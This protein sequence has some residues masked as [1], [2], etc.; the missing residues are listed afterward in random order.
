MSFFDDLLG[1]FAGQDSSQNIGG[2]EV[3]DSDVP[4]GS[5]GINRTRGST[6]HRQPT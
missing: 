5:G 1:I 6:C 3:S 2:G 4:S